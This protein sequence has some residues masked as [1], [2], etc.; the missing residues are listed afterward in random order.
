MIKW[1]ATQLA[2]HID[3]KRF[4]RPV[5]LPGLYRITLKRRY[6]PDVA[7]EVTCVPRSCYVDVSDWMRDMNI[8]W[9]GFP[10]T[11]PPVHMVPGDSIEFSFNIDF[12]CGKQAMLFKLAHGGMGSMGMQV[13]TVV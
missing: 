8:P 3:P 7:E 13:T 2:N 4:E 12:R 10:N 5:E 9:G 6:E 11:F 1:I